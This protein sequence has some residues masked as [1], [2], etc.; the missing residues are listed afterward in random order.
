MSRALLAL[1]LGLGG[2]GDTEAPGDAVDALSRRLPLCA[3]YREI[4]NAWGYCVYKHAGG[5]PTAE[6]VE[7]MC[8]SA[9]DWEA[10][11]R[12][13][14]VAG[15]MAR[16]SGVDT[17]VLLSVCA[18]N[19]DC[20]FE[21][22]DFRPEAEVTDQIDRCREHAGRHAED[23]VGHALQQWWFAKPDADE[24]A[25]IAALDSGFPRKIG[26]QVAV[27]TFCSGVGSCDGHPDNQAMCETQLDILRRRPDSC[28]SQ[29]WTVMGHNQG[30]G[31]P[32]GPGP[33]SSTGG[34]PTPGAVPAPE[35]GAPPTPGAGA[36]AQPP[37]NPEPRRHQPGTIPPAP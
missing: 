22:I 14:W 37:A 10:S 33:G 3:P 8:P 15:R 5:F 32:Q 17:D 35:D 24:V 18:G 1:V 21:L 7:A 25:R 11:C 16:G 30:R 2:C 4:P 20:A 23:C 34:P 29:K 31:A 27:S 36:A 12:H 13:A 9:G 28:P 6:D 26:Y 19:D